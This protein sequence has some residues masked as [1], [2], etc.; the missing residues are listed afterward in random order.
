MSRVKSKLATD[1]Y[2]SLRRMPGLGMSEHGH[3]AQAAELRSAA[4]V[5]ASSLTN[6]RGTERPAIAAVQELQM[7]MTDTGE[8]KTVLV[9][10]PVNEHVA[11]IDTLR[12][13]VGEE[14]WNRTAREQLVGDECF[15][16]EASRYFEEIFGFG[17]TRDLKKSRD[18]YTNAWELGDNYGYVAFGGARQRGTMLINLSG[19]GCIAAKAGWESRLHD[20]LVDTA[21]RPTITR[22][23]LAHDCM[24]GEYTVDQVDGWYDDG[25]FTCSVNAPHHEY[26]GDWK[27]PNGKGRSV[28]I[29]LRRNGKLCRAYEKGREQGDADSEWLRIEV[30]FRNNKRVI[31]FDVLLDPSSYFVGAYPCL[32][33]LDASRAP[34]KIEI[35][36]KA[37][38]INVDASL[39]NIRT[40]YGKYAF[41]LR[42]VLG[43]ADF[44][45]AITN[46]SGEWPERLKVPDFETCATPLHALPRAQVFNDLDPSGDGWTEET[47]FAPAATTGNSHAIHE[48]REGDGDEGEQRSNGKRDDLR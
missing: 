13:T 29:G 9:R 17:I 7:V 21:V 36:R 2:G 28:Y 48:Q 32:R 11:M 40:S 37:A 43:D 34:E 10:R 39:R 14:T 45:D 26:K 4:R 33:L 1:S 35:K 18:F 24:E 12:L 27:K 8:L 42:N 23:D 5:D 6:R 22:V 19:Q 31:P 46:Q 16:L 25:L 38:E 44:L 41:V 20:F 15:V 47:V 3:A 30:E